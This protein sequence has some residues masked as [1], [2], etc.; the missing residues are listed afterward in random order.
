MESLSVIHVFRR[1]VDDKHLIFR[2]LPQNMYPEYHKVYQMMR[3]S[4]GYDG[5]KGLQQHVLLEIRP[6]HKVKLVGPTCCGV[7]KVNFL[8]VTQFNID[9]Y[10]TCN[11]YIEL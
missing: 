5:Y 9:F 1:S 6:D 2:Q 10:L 8:Y 11:L 7:A 3:D 4:S